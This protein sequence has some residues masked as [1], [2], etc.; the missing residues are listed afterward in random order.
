MHNESKLKYLEFIQNIIT[1]MNKNSFQVKAMSVTITSALLAITASNFNPLYISIVY[2]SLLIF[3]GLDAFYLSQERGYRELYDEV[4]KID[5]KNT[6]IDFNLKLKKEHL[7]GKN[8]WRT[9]LTNKSIFPIYCLQA[10]IAI[11]LLV[12]FKTFGNN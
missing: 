8:S 4:R 5:I 6:N 12:T 1:R 2:L 11:I 10:I 3:W 9:V 7:Q